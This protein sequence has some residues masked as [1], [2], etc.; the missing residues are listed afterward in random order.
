VPSAYCCNDYELRGRSIAAGE[1]VLLSYESANFDE[2]Q[3][4]EPERFDIARWPN[5]HIAFGFGAHFCLG[6]QLARI[7]MRCLFRELVARTSHIELTGPA[8]L[9]PTVFVGGVKQLPVAC[10]PA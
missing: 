8:E 3:F 9:K 1:R 4:T 2:E 5:K 10:R 7:E 6:V